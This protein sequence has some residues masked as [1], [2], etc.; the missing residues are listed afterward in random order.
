MIARDDIKAC[1]DD[2]AGGATSLFLGAVRNAPW[3]PD[4]AHGPAG[5]KAGVA[6]DGICGDGAA[7]VCC[8]MHGLVI[9]AHRCRMGAM[10]W[11]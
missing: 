9:H 5:S 7:G 4:E 6:A 3:T 1:T 11:K 8:C 10:S 2:G